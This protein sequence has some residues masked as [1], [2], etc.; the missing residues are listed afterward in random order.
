MTEA[1]AEYLRLQRSLL[2]ALQGGK[3]AHCGRAL[4][5]ATAQLAHRIANS[6][7]NRKVYGKALV[8]SFRNKALVCGELHGGQDCNS[9]V[10][11]DG[12]PG[13]A[14]ALARSIRGEA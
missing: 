6:K 4:N 13:T 8:D 5:P 3:C 2:W 7:V 9:A 11:V 14:A 10:L 12:K 1:R